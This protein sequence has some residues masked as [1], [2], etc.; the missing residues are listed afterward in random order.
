MGRSKP[1]FRRACPSWAEANRV[2]AGLAQAGQTQTRF[3]AS[4]PKLGGGKPGFR[5]ACPSGAEANQVSGG[6]AQAGQRQTRFEAG[7][8]KLG[9]GK[10]SF[11]RVNTN[12]QL[13]KLKKNGKL[14][15][16]GLFQFCFARRIRKE[17][18]PELIW[19]FCSCP[20]PSAQVQSYLVEI[21]WK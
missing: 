6:L 14:I 21:S 13:R 3:Q 16:A 7:L 19:Y 20:K 12:W 4:L 17:G 18:A 1:G 9:R 15:F 8:P 10:P 5:R 2:S 11:K